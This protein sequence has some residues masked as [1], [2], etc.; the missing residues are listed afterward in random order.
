MSDGLDAIYNELRRLQKEG[1]AYVYVDGATKDLLKPAPQPTTVRERGKPVE[2]ANLA[3]LVKKTAAT[4]T[5]KP[6]PV[7]EKS[8]KRL[9]TPPQIELPEGDA[10]SQI[11]WLNER[12]LNCTTC[13]E[14]KGTE[15]KIVLGNGR[16]DADIIFCGEAPGTDDAIEGTPF[17]GGA[18][19]LLDK[20]IKAMGLNREDVYCTNILKW[21]PE[22]DKPYGNRPPTQDEM[23]FCLP[24][25][26]AE[27][28]IIQPK[29]I[30]ALGNAT[31]NGLLG[32]DP[33][34]RMASIRGTWHAFQD[35][36]LIVTFHP[37]YLLR[38][39]TLKTKRM[40]W[41]DLLSVM[42]KVE[43]PISQKQQGFFLPK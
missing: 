3:E 33:K 20:I 16:I 42:E 35:I 34:R 24:Y 31:A 27:V 8:V 5:I 6:E 41:E 36:P 1:V 4:E 7:A 26:R 28:D 21:R 37:S 9:P 11:Q 19:R 43:L 17:N 14:Q 15:G 13:I 38:N 39:D 23:H 40:V 10:T 25:F 18:G 2:H 30:V 32:P 29:V 12:I 22:N